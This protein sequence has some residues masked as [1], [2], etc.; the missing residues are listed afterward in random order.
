MGNLTLMRLPI[1]YKLHHNLFTIDYFRIAI[2]ELCGMQWLPMTALTPEIC[3]T[4]SWQA[5]QQLI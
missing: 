2:A 1:S 5:L 3:S 4:R